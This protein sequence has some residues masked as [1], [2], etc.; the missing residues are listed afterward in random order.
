M[1]LMRYRVRFSNVDE[2]HPVRFVM[3]LR[4]LLLFVP[5]V[6][7]AAEGERQID[8]VG[9]WDKAWE[10]AKQKNCPVMICFNS[11][12]GEKANEATAKEIY[13]D[14][15]FVAL[16]RSFVM[17]VL[18]VPRHKESGPCPRF[19]VVTCAEHLQCEQAFAA[20]YGDRFASPKAHGEMI[21]PQHAWFTPDGDLLSRKEFWMDKAELLRRMRKAL[22]DMAAKGKEKG[23]GEGGTPPLEG[24]P[25]AT[26]P[27][28]DSEKA[29]L[30]KA[31]GSDAE[32]RKTALGNLLATEKPSVRA[33]IIDLLNR[34]TDAGVKCDAMRALGLAQVMDGRPAIEAHLEHKDPLVRSFAAVALERLAQ[35][36]SIEPL[37]KRAKSEHDN[38]ARKNACRALGACGGPAADESAA[39]ALLKT[40]ANDKQNMIRKHAA[41]ALRAYSDEKAAALVVT[42]LEQLALKTK[43]QAVRG[44]I[45]FTLAFIG[46]RET[47]EPV[48]QKILEDTNDDR[49]KSFLRMA[50]RILRKESGDFGRDAWWLFWEDRD[51]PARSDDI[52]KDIPGG[53]K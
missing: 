47:T 16:S 12:D 33:A 42:K 29:D 17:V 34:A 51:D 49:A 8:W 10:L 35:K 5:L 25:P 20:K 7:A 15:E 40:I 27:L 4:T 44:A 18:S 14:P 2:K 6:A 9:D 23:P 48:L 36:E 37:L 38:T 3:R 50:L 52:P 39:T 28:S 30:A 22:E 21:T 31:E 32:A 13:H 53:G 45:V 41:L 43:D 26:P 46:K 24:T 1:R 11:K 19:G